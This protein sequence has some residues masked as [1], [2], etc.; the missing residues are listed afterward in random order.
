MTDSAIEWRKQTCFRP[1]TV[2]PAK[3][4]GHSAA[5]RSRS[6]VC[7][8]SLALP[9]RNASLAT[10][11]D[12]PLPQRRLRPCEAIPIS[13]LENSCR[14]TTITLDMLRCQVSGVFARRGRHGMLFV[15]IRKSAPIRYLPTI[16]AKCPIN[17][18]AN[19]G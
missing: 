19:E 1:T 4:Y 10:P 5:C 2:R 7:R 9:D 3:A 12:N 8:L 15:I 18:P 11:R 14:I 6:T 13:N 17:S 16:C